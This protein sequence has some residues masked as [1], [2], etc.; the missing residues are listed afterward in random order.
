MGVS[1][2]AVRMIVVGMR[3]IVRVIRVIVNVVLRLGVRRVRV[4]VVSGMAVLPVWGR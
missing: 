4:A 3:V 2:A 1:V